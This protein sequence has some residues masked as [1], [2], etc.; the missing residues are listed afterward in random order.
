M[1]VESG[2]SAD[3]VPFTR[4]SDGLFN[5]WLDARN[6]AMREPTRVNADAAGIAWAAFMDDFLPPDQRQQSVSGK[7][8]SLSDLRAKKEKREGGK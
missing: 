2:H 7:Y 4:K 8:V 3:V 6:L 1:T 5:A